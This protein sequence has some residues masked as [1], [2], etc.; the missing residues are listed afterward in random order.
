[1]ASL[2]PMQ[3]KHYGEQI[4]NHATC[5]LDVVSMGQH[6]TMLIIIVYNSSSSSR[7]RRRRGGGGGGGTRRSSSRSRSSN[8]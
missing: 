8:Y 1:M 4:Q 5:N 6:C 7:R 2:I 3:H